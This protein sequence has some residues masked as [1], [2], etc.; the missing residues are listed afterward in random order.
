MASTMRIAIAAQFFEVHGI[1][2]TTAAGLVRWVARLM[3]DRAY[4]EATSAVLQHFR[5]ERQSLQLAVRI[6]GGKDFFWQTNFNP[7]PDPK[8]HCFTHLRFRSD[9][10]DV[11]LH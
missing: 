3:R 6:E 9:P 8:F 2:Q 4:P 10:E 11:E 7:V 1:V 5:H